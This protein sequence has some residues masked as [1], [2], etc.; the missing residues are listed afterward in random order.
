MGNRLEAEY[1]HA[2][3][4]LFLDF[5]RII[6]VFHSAFGSVTSTEFNA[7]DMLVSFDHCFQ[8][9]LLEGLSF[10]R[11]VFSIKITV[12]EVTE[13]VTVSYFT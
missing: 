13:L 1:C 4:S 6:A 12:F 9:N 8:F 3:K 2:V 11:M 10:M 5:G 7:F